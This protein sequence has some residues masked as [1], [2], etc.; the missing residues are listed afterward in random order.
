VAT[1]TRDGKRMI[2]VVLGAPSSSARAIKAAQL[3]ERGFASNPLSWLT[4]SLGSVEAL[5]PVNIDP[6]NLREE[7][8]GKSR[9]RQASE[10]EDDS[11]AVASFSADSPYAVFLS[12]LRAPSNKTLLLD[13]RLGE[14]VVVFTGT[15]PKPDTGKSKTANVDPKAAK[16]G[17]KAKAKPATATLSPTEGTDKPTPAKPKAT[18]KAATTTETPKSDASKSAPKGAAKKSQD[19]DKSKDKSAQ[20]TSQTSEKK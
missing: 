7:M 9:K 20:K 3:L 17:S 16:P 2:A 11:A 10:D 13:Q 1:A 5:Q 8:C 12:S 15:S 6:P 14:P 19:K 4:P 18:K